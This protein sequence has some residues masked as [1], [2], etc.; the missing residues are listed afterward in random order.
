MSK[1]SVV[2]PAEAVVYGPFASRAEADRLVDQIRLSDDDLA[3]SYE[4]RP[5]PPWAWTIS[6]RIKE[7][8][9]R[10]KP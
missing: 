4:L 1:W 7:T 5:C 9:T 6:E 3:W 2:Y 8:R 10:R